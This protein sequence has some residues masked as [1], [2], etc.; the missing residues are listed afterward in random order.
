MIYYKVLSVNKH[1]NQLV[2]LHASHDF[3]KVYIPNEWVSAKKELLEEGYGLCVFASLDAA[4][5]TYLL[6][7]AT[8]ATT[9]IWEC[10]GRGEMD[11]PNRRLSTY[12]F[13]NTQVSEV[14]INST[15]PDWPA[16]TVM[17]EKV[18]LTKK[19]L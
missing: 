4:K 13:Y 8:G 16:Y 10:K 3:A 19:L 14:I 11:L 6:V 7:G 1:T 17:F 5:A 15:I 2:S 18:K 12:D 9:E